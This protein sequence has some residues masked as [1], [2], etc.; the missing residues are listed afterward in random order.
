MYKNR[1]FS[2]LELII[3]VAVLAVI[4]VIGSG[5]YVNYGKN[6]STKSVSQNIVFDLKS[7]QSKSMIG[8]GDFKWG[9]HFVNGVKD[10]YEIFST[11]TD[12]SSGSKVV[13]LTKY[14]SD[15]VS[16]SDANIP[17]TKDVIFNKISG[18]TTASTIV[19]VSS[20]V[21]KTIDISSIGNISIQ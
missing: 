18:G 21:T 8:E 7:A 6:I 15:S 11:P 17:S 1:A 10:Y 13:I 19:V 12:Y 20:S 16:Y 5:F 3:V 14:L 9:I 2:L 4:G